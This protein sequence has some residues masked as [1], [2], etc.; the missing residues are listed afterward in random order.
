MLQRAEPLRRS[1]YSV[2]PLHADSSLIYPW[3]EALGSPVNMFWRKPLNPTPSNPVQIDVH[4]ES[5]TRTYSIS[6]GL[7]LD[8][9]IIAR[10][11]SLLGEFVTTWE[12]LDEG[13]LRETWLRR[14]ELVGDSVQEDY[15]SLPFPIANDLR[16]SQFC[17][18]SGR[19]ILQ[20]LCHDQ[21]GFTPC[22]VYHAMLP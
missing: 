3:P 7:G 20:R 21:P 2:V 12:P 22:R 16:V 4:F 6:S 17:H 15:F 19:L 1:G 14:Q 11:C 18:L 13:V 8:T 10:P 5:G 9:E